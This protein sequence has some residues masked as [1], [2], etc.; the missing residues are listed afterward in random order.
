MV[1]VK[2]LLAMTR[3]LTSRGREV[4]ARRVLPWR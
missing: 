3:L 1:E 4:Q 2:R